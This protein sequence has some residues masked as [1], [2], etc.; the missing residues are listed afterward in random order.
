[1]IT[2]LYLENINHVAPKKVDF[3]LLS[4]PFRVLLTDLHILHKKMYIWTRQYRLFS[5]FCEVALAPHFV[6]KN[7]RELFQIVNK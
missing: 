3:Y 7:S 6:K 2:K 5:C 4:N 1:M